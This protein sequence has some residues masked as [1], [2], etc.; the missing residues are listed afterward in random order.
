MRYSNSTAI[1]FKARGPRP[2]VAQSLLGYHP[3]GN[4]TRSRRSLCTA[5]TW[6]WSGV[7]HAPNHDIGNDSLSPPHLAPSGFLPETPLRRRTMYS[8]CLTAHTRA[9]RVMHF[10]ISA[11]AIDV[12]DG[13]QECHRSSA[14]ALCEASPDLPVP[15][16]SLDPV[17]A[18][19]A[20]EGPSARAAPVSLSISARSR[21]IWLQQ[22]C[23]PALGTP[24]VLG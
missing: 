24:N 17:A 12:R 19:V 8:R 20:G 5:S 3:L 13:R 22:Y 18:L 6:G 21:I 1:N 16:H 7:S 9:P 2:Q 4:R 11:G 10:R 14:I 15:E 23:Q